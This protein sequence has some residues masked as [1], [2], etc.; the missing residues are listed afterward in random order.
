MK[1]EEVAIQNVSIDKNMIRYMPR[2]ACIFV[3][4]MLMMFCAISCTNDPIVIESFPVEKELSGEHIKALDTLKRIYGIKCL[5]DKYYVSSKNEEYFVTVFDGDFN[6]QCKLL[7]RGHGHNEW[8]APL[9]TGQL[10]PD[11][12]SSFLY[13]LERESDVLYTIDT[14]SQK[15]TKVIDFPSCDLSGISYVYKTN[16]HQFI[17]GRMTDE[18]E[19]F[20]Y[21]ADRKKIEEISSSKIEKEI[22][23]AG[24]F[25]LSQTIS[26]FNAKQKTMAVGY[27][28]FPLIDITDGVSHTTLQIGNHFPTYDKESI[29]DA[30]FYVVDICSTDS[31]IYILYDDPVLEDEMSI[32]VLDWDGIG[33]A[34]YHVPRLVCFTVN[35][36]GDNIIGVKEDD[37]S[38]LCYSF[39]IMH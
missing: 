26:T 30:H 6:Q 15:A 21:D 33:K 17:G 9:V 29:S 34:R 2:R 23:S 32:L 5:D 7:K 3:L 10:H 8:M 31:N 11:E 18:G 19:L 25:E 12:D 24:K 27:F 1:K 13:V 16:D 14:T 20:L 37:S 22:F 38:G 28:N 35:A 39:R 4:Y 36:S